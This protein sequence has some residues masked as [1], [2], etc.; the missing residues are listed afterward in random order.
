MKIVY[1]DGHREILLNCMETLTRNNGVI[2]YE[3]R[4]INNDVLMGTGLLN[5]NDQRMEIVWTG[6]QG[7]FSYHEFQFFIS[8]DRIDDSVNINMVKEALNHLKR[9]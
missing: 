3:F 2:S 1:K 9:N 7:I 6:E 5:I 4:L 8:I